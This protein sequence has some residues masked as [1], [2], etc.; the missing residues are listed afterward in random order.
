MYVLTYACVGFG[1][2]F[3][4]FRVSYPFAVTYG[5]RKPRKLCE[6]LS[7][8]R[9]RE[10]EQRVREV[11]GAD[12]TCFRREV[13]VLR[14]MWPS[15]AWSK[16]AMKREEAYSH[17]C[18]LVRCSFAF[19]LARSALVC[20]RGTRSRHVHVLDPFRFR[21]DVAMHELEMHV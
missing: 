2:A 13:W 12:F 8:M 20:L 7:K 3:F 18:G 16:L 1:D 6:H 10:Y 17:V 5:N 11:D 4:E 9:K 19:A 15:K 21:A 14:W